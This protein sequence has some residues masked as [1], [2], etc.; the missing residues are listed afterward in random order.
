MGVIIFWLLL[1]LALVPVLA[2]YWARRRLVRYIGTVTGVAFGAVIAPLAFGAYGAGMSFPVVG[3]PLVMVGL[4]FTIFHGEPGF[5]MALALGLV[6]P[7]RV[8]EGIQHLYVELLFGL[9][10]APAYGLIGLAV[11]RVRLRRA[12]RLREDSSTT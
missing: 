12:T 7:G 3:F 8:V 10:W 5:K 1:L 6:Q 4:A 2:H 9:I 11:D